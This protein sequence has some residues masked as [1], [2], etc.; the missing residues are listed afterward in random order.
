MTIEDLRMQKSVSQPEFTPGG[1]AVF[2]MNIEASE[3][4]DAS[5]IVVTDTL[6]D[7][8]CPLGATGTTYWA[9]EPTCTAQASDPKPSPGYSSV[10]G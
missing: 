6:P 10:P 9:A 3:Y 1:T 2:T 4:M 5:N 7:G 8:Y